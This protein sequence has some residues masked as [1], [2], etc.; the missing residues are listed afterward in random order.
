METPSSSRLALLLVVAL[1]VGSV[2]GVATDPYLPSGV[3]NTKK[4]YA[5]GFSAARKIAEESSYGKMF[6][7]AD[8][9]RSLS[10]LVTEMNGDALTLKLSSAMSPFDDASLAVRTVRITPDTKL[11]KLV[12]K[13]PKAFQAEL[14]KFNTSA[15]SAGA[16]AP[17][18]Y[19]QTVISAAGIKTG[20]LLTVMAGENVKTLKE[21]AASEIRV[22]LNMMSK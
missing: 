22:E 12:A 14:S 21:F 8:D 13:D 18:P 10:G 5:A 15:S 2:I 11:V 3:S 19:L 20:D 17:Q 16:T 1:V 4:G 9:V 6:V 7:T